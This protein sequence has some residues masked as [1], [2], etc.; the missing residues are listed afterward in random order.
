MIN[1]TFRWKFMNSEYFRYIVE[2]FRP[3]NSETTIS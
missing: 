2:I 3:L 1:V